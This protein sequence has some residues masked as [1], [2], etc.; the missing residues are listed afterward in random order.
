[1]KL[2]VVAAAGFLA[3]A[4]AAGAWLL[5]H[6]AGRGGL[7]GDAAHDESSRNTLTFAQ[8]SSR[9]DAVLLADIQPG[10]RASTVATRL[11]VVNVSASPT[12][13]FTL[14]DGA[15]LSWAPPDRLAS[16]ARLLELGFVASPQ[17]NP[18]VPSSDPLL[19]DPQRSDGGATQ[20]VVL[21]SRGGL[22]AVFT[23]TKLGA[24]AAALWDRRAIGFPTGD[25]RLVYVTPD[26]I[27]VPVSS[28]EHP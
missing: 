9:E 28:R 3:F 17:G 14:Y 27:V 24:E 21:R 5:T 8:W 1:M 26:A 13:D 4:V 19:G 18:I 20:I 7:D 2:V 12:G 6:Q 22:T 25:G 11:L 16:A 10:H 23:R 15:A